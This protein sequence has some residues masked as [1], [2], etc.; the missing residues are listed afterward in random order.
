MPKYP[1]PVELR[2]DGITGMRDT[3]T[4]IADQTKAFLLKNCYVDVPEMG[5]SAVV[6]RDGFRRLSS[7]AIGTS[8]IATGLVYDFF[9]LDGTQHTVFIAAGK[10]YK[11]TWS[12][13]VL[14]EVLTAADLSGASVAIDS[15]ATVYACTFNNQMVI[16]DGVN[17]PWMWDGT[18]NGGITKLTNAPVAWGPPTVYYAK[19]FF[20]KNSDRGTIVWSEEN[21]ANTGYEA[22]GSD[23][24]W[25]LGQ[26]GSQPLVAIHGTNE[27]LY[28]FRLQSIGVV[29]GAVEDDFA[30]T[31][32]HDAVSSEIGMRAPMALLY[33]GKTFYF[34]D[35]HLRPWA[36]RLGG[37]PVPWW[38]AA[39]RRFIDMSRS[40]SATPYNVGEGTVLRSN[41][42]AA[43][44]VAVAA[45]PYLGQ[46]T[47]VYHDTSASNTF[48]L[49]FHAV[50][51]ELV[52]EDEYPQLARVGI[53]TK[54]D[55]SNI[56]AEGVLAAI[57]LT[58]VCCVM[59]RT[60]AVSGVDM[61]AAAAVSNYTATIVGPMQ[62]YSHNVE[63]LFDLIDVVYDAQNSGATPDP[64]IAVDYL[65]S[66]AHY[67]TLME[68]AQTIT[69]S[70]SATPI[71]RQTHTAV[72]ILGLGRWIR[73]RLV[74]TPTQLSTGTNDERM[75][76][77]GWTVTAI[78]Q[79][80]V[81]GV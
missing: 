34:C 79:P 57:S 1:K 25:T 49:N 73:V 6:V 72:G 76:V 14:T 38:K 66:T 26:A 36:M 70:H 51:G 23:N 33:Y 8:G 48:A 47:F 37:E 68:A 27:G 63:W 19:L 71:L 29:R 58:G 62:G 52:G 30:S 16:S 42:N 69:A 7:T 11:Y 81:Y 64:T 59:G 67:S 3:L 22:A 2:V 44:R 46:I 77:Y 80:S 10:F 65:T 24:A 5:P 54:P 28:Y 35:Q 20:I 61:T 15:T 78:P 32:T 12:S 60:N 13:G 41:L 31:G 4:P 43:P 18:S 55:V 75:A 9:K 74:L 45:K 50:S 39:E 21:A 40:I 53:L 56:P 17:T